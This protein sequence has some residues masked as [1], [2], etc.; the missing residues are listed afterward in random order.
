MIN[1]ALKQSKLDK[2]IEL[3]FDDNNMF[4]RTF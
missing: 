1:A 3:E 4:I 2:Y